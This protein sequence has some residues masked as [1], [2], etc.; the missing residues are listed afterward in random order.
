MKGFRWIVLA[1]IV[2]FAAG[3]STL[4][5]AERVVLDLGFTTF[6]RAPLVTV[7]LL[8][9]L[10]GMV[11]MFLM[12]LQQDLRLRQYVREREAE[13][14]RSRAAEPWPGRERGIGKAAEPHED[15]ELERSSD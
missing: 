3:L 10:L 9:F 5:R 7:L 15:R 2:A 1:G 4:N 13:L 6:Y 8:S 12:G 11:A 14:A